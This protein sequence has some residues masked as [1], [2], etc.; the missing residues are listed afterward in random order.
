MVKHVLVTGDTHGRVS[1]RLVYI[2]N[3]MSDYDPSETAVIILGDVGFNYY[4]SKS[5]WK[6]KQEAARF[7][8]TLYCLRGNHEDRASNMKQ[9]IETY[10]E[11][12]HGYVI[13][14]KDFPNIK[15][16]S[17]EIATYNI[18]GKVVLCVPGAYSVDKWYRLQ[19]NWQWFAEEQ[20]TTEEMAH[21]EK[22]FSG[23]HFDVVLSHTCPIDWEP[24]DLFLRSIDQS[25]VDKTMEI[26]L[27]KFKDMISWNLWLFGHYH[28]DRIERPYVEQFYQ[29]V[30]DW[31]TIWDRWTRYHKT[32]ELDWWLP[33]SPNFYS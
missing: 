23:Y 4:K 1:E 13:Y 5:D 12:V 17:D 29:E 16:F 3:M 32:G 22:D 27:G 2:K 11:F 15:Y 19:N 6:H 21:A 8:Y 7:G 26:W 10:D 18:M 28:S 9:F 24:R 30:E 14:E 20:L 33:K 25:K 31:D